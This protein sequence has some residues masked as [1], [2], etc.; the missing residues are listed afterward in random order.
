MELAEETERGS[1]PRDDVAAVLAALLR[2]P[3]TARRTLDLVAGETPVDDAV[4][5]MARPA[6]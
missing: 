1:I 5:R 3:G 2:A 6:A 4:I